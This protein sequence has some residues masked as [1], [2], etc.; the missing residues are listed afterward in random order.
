MNPR[1]AAE[2][3]LGVAGVWLIVSRIPELGVSL[4]YPIAEPEGSLPWF[5]VVHVGLVIVCGLG[6]LLLRHRIASWLVP[7]SQPDLSGSVAGFQAAAFSVLGLFLLAQG[8]ADILA[9]LTISVSG[10][11][12]SSFD[13]FAGPI[14]QTAVG[15]ALFLGARGVATIWQ[16]LRTAGRPSGG[17]DAG[18]A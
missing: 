2:I 14:A 7:T 12:G 6:L 10:S 18:A 11:Q 1:N 17:G 5:V 16:S 9:Q 3:A 8:L 4:V 15:L 13:R